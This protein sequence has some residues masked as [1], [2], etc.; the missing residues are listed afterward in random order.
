MNEMQKRLLSGMSTSDLPFYNQQTGEALPEATEYIEGTEFDSQGRP[1]P[2]SE[3]MLAT[4]AVPKSM[5]PVH[6]ANDI[7]QQLLKEWQ[8]GFAE[9][10]SSN[11]KGGMLTPVTEKVEE[12]KQTK[13]T[14]NP[15]ESIKPDEPTR[16]GWM[17][18][19]DAEGNINGNYWSV[20]EN[21]PYWQTEEGYQEAMNLYG[22]KPGWITRPVEKE[23]FVD[24]AVQSIAPNLKK[25]F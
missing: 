11:K 18:P 8:K 4:E 6:A 5:D 15:T 2:I 19:R 25:Y 10:F 9:F 1:I 13:F 7:G 20:N 23:D 22:F 24:L 17:L 14:G 16:P 21:D 3:R 12:K